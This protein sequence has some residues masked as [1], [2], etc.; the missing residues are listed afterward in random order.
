[1]ASNSTEDLVSTLA[2]L[3]DPVEKH[4][5]VKRCAEKL[6]LEEDYIWQ[7]LEKLGSGRR[8]TRSTQPKRPSYRAG[9]RN[10]I[11]RKL[12]ECLIQYPQFINQARL[13]LTKDDFSNPHHAELAEILWT[14]GN[15]GNG[16]LDLG[17]LL[18]KCTSTESRDIVKNLVLEENSFPNADAYFAGCLKKMMEFRNREVRRSVVKDGAEDSVSMARRLMELR[19]QAKLKNGDH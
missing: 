10:A 16:R 19:Q 6:S 3:T 5:Y 1:M 7:E 4:E 2:N 9:A 8:I 11:E 12:L 14:D 15:N 17:E 13:E 18:D